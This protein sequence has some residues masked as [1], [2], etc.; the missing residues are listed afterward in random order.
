MNPIL[1]HNISPQV[2]TK[3]YDAIVGKLKKI[4]PSTK[5]IGISLAFNGRPEF[6]E[7]FLNPKNHKPGIPLDGI[8][9]HFYGTP[10]YPGQKLE[11]YQYTFF[12]KANAFLEKVKFIESIRK[13]LSPKTITTI[14]EIG[15]I[16]NANGDDI[17]DDYWNLSGAM[18][19]YIFLELTRTWALMLQAN[20]SWLVIQHS[21]LM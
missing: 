9:Y 6:F 16:I 18:F 1:E 3:M 17:P 11:D 7:Y 12:D 19:A 2:Y 10:S 20:R 5:F 8:S 14:N 13:R 4:S 15:T 21:F